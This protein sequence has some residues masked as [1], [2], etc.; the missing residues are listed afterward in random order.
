M[1][2]TQ[3]SN[4]STYCQLTLIKQS[5]L[6]T[7]K[8]NLRLYVQVMLFRWLVSM[9]FNKISATILESGEPMARPSF[10]MNIL[11]LNVK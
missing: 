2:L 6:S 4:I 3:L 7:N 11:T 5:M 10:W 9:W 1:L 8:N